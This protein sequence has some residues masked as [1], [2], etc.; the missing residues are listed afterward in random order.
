ML[1]GTPTTKTLAVDIYGA[2]RPK[3]QI[4]TLFFRG[5]WVLT[6]R[7]G[8][9]ILVGSVS[10]PPLLLWNPEYYVDS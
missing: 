6:P 1:G 2:L 4:K 8:R 5:S 3:T 9:K 10:V 7:G